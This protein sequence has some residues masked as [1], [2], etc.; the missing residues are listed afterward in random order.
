[1]IYNL[2]FHNVPESSQEDCLK[3]IKDNLAARLGW[4]PELENADREGNIWEDRKPRPILCKFLYRPEL[5][6]KSSEIGKIYPASG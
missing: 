6:F 4:E 3:R 1:M 5:G 2:R